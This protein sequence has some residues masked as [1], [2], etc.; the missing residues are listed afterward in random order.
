MKRSFGQALSDVILTDIKKLLALFKYL[1][2]RITPPKLSAELKDDI[3]KQTIKPKQ[4]TNTTIEAEIYGWRWKNTAPFVCCCHSHLL[5][6][7]K[8]NIVYGPGSI[9]P[10]QNEVFCPYCLAHATLPIIKDDLED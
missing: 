6:E 8:V 10:G 5:L 4:R 2:T 9:Y 7:V 3:V 1:L